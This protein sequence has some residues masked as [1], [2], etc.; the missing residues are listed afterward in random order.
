MCGARYVILVTVLVAGFGV[1]AAADDGTWDVYDH[2]GMVKN[3]ST[4]W[5]PKTPGSWICY[6]TAGSELWSFLTDYTAPFNR[7]MRAVAAWTHSWDHSITGGMAAV[8]TTCFMLCSDV[9]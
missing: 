7:C 2:D 5:K 4:P 3:N 9:L 8:L 1:A 6:S